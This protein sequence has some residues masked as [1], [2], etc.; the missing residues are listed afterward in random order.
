MILKTL[1]LCTTLPIATKLS[2]VV[3]YLEGLLPINLC[4][5]L[6]TWYYEITCQ[7][8][9]MHPLPQYLA[10]YCVPLPQYLAMT[11]K[12]GQLHWGAPSRKVTWSFNHVVLWDHVTNQIRYISTWAK[13][14]TVNDMTWLGVIEWLRP[15]KPQNPLNMDT[16]LV[17]EVIYH[18]E[19]LSIKSYDSFIT[20]SF[21]VTWQIKFI[22]RHI[23]IKRGM[24]VT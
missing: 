6:I 22:R 13:S 9:D 4:E 8:K 1:Y 18:Q 24:V 21:Q 3:F 7:I 12:L 5:F 11:T 16:K 23:G 14:M 19:L 15:V 20:C 10:R 17:K 2:S